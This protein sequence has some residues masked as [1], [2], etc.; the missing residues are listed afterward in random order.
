LQL[1]LSERNF[2]GLLI[3]FS[4]TYS[5][6]LDNSSDPLLPTAGNGNF[7]VDS[8]LP[9]HEYGN[10]GTDVRQ[11]G[12]INF[13]YQAPVGR[14]TSRW[15]Q[16]FIGRAFEG[17]ELSGI[18]QFQTGLPYDI[19]NSDDNGQA[20][21]V[22]DTLHTGLADRATV[23]G[24]SSRQ[25]GTDEAFT[26]PPISAFTQT[27]AFGVPS[28]VGRNHWYGPGMDNWDFVLAKNTSI[29]ERF[30][31]QLRLESYNIFNH[32]HFAKPDNFL[33][34]PFYGESLSQVGQNDG[35]TG[36]RQLQIGAKLVF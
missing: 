24:S 22:I 26:G 34:S 32:V 21:G 3:Q 18:G 16:G 13:V 14:G 30:K 7:P 35:S 9:Q 6:A 10:S 1:Q 4:Y 8:F 15:N 25:P 12:V 33:F 11:R 28:N 29:S 20:N 2:H 5:H 17:W 36:A 23:V 19:F 31:L 27:P